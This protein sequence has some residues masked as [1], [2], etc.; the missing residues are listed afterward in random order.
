VIRIEQGP[1]NK[2]PLHQQHV[3]RS[4]LELVAHIRAVV[5]A[6]LC[7]KLCTQEGQVLEQNCDLGIRRLHIRDMWELSVQA[8]FKFW[9]WQSRDGLGYATMHAVYGA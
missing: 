5:L 1:E 3:K 4:E 8:A 9:Q 6:R 2:G 7:A